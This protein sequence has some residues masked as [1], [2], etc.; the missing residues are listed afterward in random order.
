[1][2]KHFANGDKPFDGPNESGRSGPENDG[3]E[4][5]RV[6]ANISVDINGIA[7]NTMFRRTMKTGHYVVPL[8]VK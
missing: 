3:K 7:Y 4:E 2:R 6:R 8:L 5:K 1:M